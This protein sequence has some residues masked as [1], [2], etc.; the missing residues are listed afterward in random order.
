MMTATARAPQP[1]NAKGRPV[2]AERPSTNFVSNDSS[3]NTI[4]TL[5]AQRLRLLGIIGQRAQLIANLAWEVSH[6]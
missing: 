1:G 2:R 3:L 6:G 4:D 5:R